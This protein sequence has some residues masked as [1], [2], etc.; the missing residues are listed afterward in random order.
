MFVLTLIFP[1]GNVES[2]EAF[3]QG[4]V[5]LLVVEMEVHGLEKTPIEEDEVAVHQSARDTHVEGTVE[6]ESFYCQ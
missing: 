1:F 4:Q 2:A 3:E 6:G 5:I